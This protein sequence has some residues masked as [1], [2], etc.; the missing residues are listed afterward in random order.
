MANNSE[1]IKDSG[2]I[3]QKLSDEFKERV[4]KPENTWIKNIDE[5][6]SVNIDMNA[7]IV[8]GP[9]KYAYLEDVQL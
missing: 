9:E 7:S 2:K 4:T 3:R 6:C 1:N 8:E 5:L